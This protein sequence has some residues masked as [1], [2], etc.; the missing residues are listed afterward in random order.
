MNRSLL[1]WLSI[2]AAACLGFLANALFAQESTVVIRSPIRGRAAT[3]LSEALAKPH[4]LIVGS[5][6]RVDL[7]RDTTYSTTVI[8]IGARTTVAS[9]VN[10]DVIVI[11]GDLFTHPGAQIHGRVIAIGGGTYGSAL[12]KVD[13]GGES[14]ADAA[15]EVARTPTAIELQDVGTRAEQVELIV[16]PLAYGLRIPEYNRVDG[17]ALPFG[18]RINLVGGRVTIDPLLT[19]RSNLG[20][21][22]PSASAV[23]RLARDWTLD[24]D[25]GRST[26]SNDRWIQSDLTNSVSSLLRGIDYRNYYRAEFA[27]ARLSRLW[28]TSGA[29]VRGW[30]GAKTER[31]RSVAAGGPWSFAHR[32]DAEEGM[33]RPNPAIEPGRISSGLAGGSIDWESQGVH[34]TLRAEIESPFETPRDERFQQIVFEGRI[35]FPTFRDQRFDLFTHNVI[36]FGDTTPRQRFAYLGGQGTIPT[37]EKLS[38]G[39]DQLVFIESNYTI[40]VARWEIPLLG[41]PTFVLRHLIGAADVRRLRAF[42]QNVGLRAQLSFIR[43]EIFFDPSTHKSTGGVGLSLL[44]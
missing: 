33:Y 21:V 16:L 3:I 41:S 17:L 9:T 27:E 30:I 8:V 31:A 11:N 24:A 32:R 40:P 1:R 13:G 6:Q 26:F 10:G 22:D 18:P 44:R 38:R 35:G 42:D 25:G 37:L 20:E 5:G 14:F 28:Q 29:D 12:A 19:Y 7:R 4:H 36:T 15:W 2:C 34:A 23:V 43:A 39:G